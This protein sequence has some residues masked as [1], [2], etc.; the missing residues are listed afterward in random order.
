MCNLAVFPSC[1]ECTR[2]LSWWCYHWTP[3]AKA[4]VA[5]FSARELRALKCCL[6]SAFHEAFWP[7][8][9][10]VLPYRWWRPLPSRT[11]FCGRPSALPPARRTSGASIWPPLV[12]TCKLGHDRCP[13]RITLAILVPGTAQFA[14]QL[15]I[16]HINNQ[17]FRNRRMFCNRRMFALSIHDVSDYVASLFHLRSVFRVGSY[18]CASSQRYL[19]IGCRH[20]CSGSAEQIEG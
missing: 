16:I 9:C 11:T 18:L 8:R 19:L 2:D 14:I 7:F 3:L 6:T 13:H 10:G 12:F 17:S 15:G 5:A 4:S 20:L 1:P